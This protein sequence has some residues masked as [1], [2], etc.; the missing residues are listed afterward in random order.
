MKAKILQK[1]DDLADYAREVI[2]EGENNGLLV[3]ARFDGQIGGTCVSSMQTLSELFY[4]LFD[5]VPNSVLAAEVAIEAYHN[6]QNN[7]N[8]IPN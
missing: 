3:I 8:K 4:N 6:I 1:V 7:N 5:E 2:N